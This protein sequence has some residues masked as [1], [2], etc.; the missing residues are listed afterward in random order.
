MQHDKNV[1]TVPKNKVELLTAISTT[2]D[3][4]MA[5]LERVPKNRAREC[6]L[7]G[8]VAGTT[9]SPS[10]LLSYL[11][12]WNQLG[13]LARK[14]YED[15]RSLSYSQLLARLTR[16]KSLI[17]ENIS[18]RQNDELYGVAWYGKWTK[19]RM[20]QL[21]TSSPYTN[22]RGRIRKWLKAT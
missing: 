18:D 13:P 1:M 14:F 3:K 21:N 10:G 5:D 6:T 19:G 8:H 16:A 2:F 12:G 11:I 15:Y 20:I 7:D 17:V 4:L 9:M 22:A